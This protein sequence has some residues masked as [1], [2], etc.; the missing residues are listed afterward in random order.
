MVAKFTE[1]V[2]KLILCVANVARF[3][4]MSIFRPHGAGHFFNAHRVLSARKRSEG[5]D[6]FILSSVNGTSMYHC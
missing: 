2:G 3:I 1:V 5:I 4:L 6:T